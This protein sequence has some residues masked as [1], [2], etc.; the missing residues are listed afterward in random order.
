MEERADIMTDYQMRT[1]MNLI[2]SIVQD[3]KKLKSPLEEIEEKLIEIRDGE[4]AK[5]KEKKEPEV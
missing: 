2:I 1:L 5:R 4:F 3:A